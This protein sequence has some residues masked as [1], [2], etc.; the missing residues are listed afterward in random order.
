MTTREELKA[1]IDQFSADTDTTR[2]FVHG[3]EDADVMLGDPAAGGP[4]PTATPTLRKLV[5]SI[6]TIASAAIADA[7]GGL[8]ELADRSCE[9]ADNA[10]TS[11]EAALAAQRNAHQT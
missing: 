4:E 3:G 11:A 2:A 6:Q 10:N 9:C 1:K 5:K 8:R 7:E